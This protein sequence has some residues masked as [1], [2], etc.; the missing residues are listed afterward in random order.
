MMSEYWSGLFLVGTLALSL[1]LIGA[2]LSMMLLKRQNRAVSLTFLSIVSLLLAVWVADRLIAGAFCYPWECISP[3]A[4]TRDLLLK[5]ADLPEGWMVGTTLDYTYDTRAAASYDERSFLSTRGTGPHKFYQEIY[6]YRSV[7]GASFQ[8]EGLRNAVPG[9]YVHPAQPIPA[10]LSFPDSH[11]AKYFIGRLDDSGHVIYYVAE[12]QQY[13][14]VLAIPF[15]Q[16]GI[17]PNEFIAL[18]RSVDK[19][20]YKV[21]SGSKAP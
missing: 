21:L 14:V 11:A 12:Y 4:D 19:K 20:F 17:P 8:Y 10:Q 15:S 18:V 7:R 6:Q 1:V 3:Q 9:Q 16:Q 5:Q 2:I 13:L